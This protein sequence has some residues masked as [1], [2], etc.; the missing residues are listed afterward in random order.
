MP[1]SWNVCSDPHHWQNSF[2]YAIVLPFLGWET[3]AV[4]GIWLRQ[5]CLRGSQCFQN[6]HWMPRKQEWVQWEV[7][8]GCNKG[9][10]TTQGGGSGVG[11]ALQFPKWGKGPR[12]QAFVL[13]HPMRAASG[14]QSVGS[15]Q[16]QQGP[17]PSPSAGSALGSWG[18]D[19]EWL[20]LRGN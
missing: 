4:G 1:D 17:T 15:L 8:C 14:K 12:G 16:P 18:R 3:R 13:W 19:S 11:K 7:Q 9:P 10:K 20:I 5:T 2:L 6:Y